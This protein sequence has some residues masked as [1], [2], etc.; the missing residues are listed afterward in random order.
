M[1]VLQV[2]LCSLSLKSVPIND[3]ELQEIKLLYVLTR[4]SNIECLVSHSSLTPV[5]CRLH[6]FAVRNGWAS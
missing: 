1:R 4:C 2:H 5:G 6:T 3:V